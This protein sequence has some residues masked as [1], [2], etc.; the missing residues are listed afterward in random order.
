MRSKGFPF[1][2]RDLGAG[3]LFTRCLGLRPREGPM[4]RPLANAARKGLG[5]RKKEEG[6]G[7]IGTRGE[8]IRVRGFILFYADKI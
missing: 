3:N 7:R 6:G 4:A 2:Y 8:D 5:R 1:N